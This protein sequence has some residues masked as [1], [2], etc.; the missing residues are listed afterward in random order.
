MVPD[1]DPQ[2][3]P[4]PHGEDRFVGLIVSDKK[5]P[6]TVEMIHKGERSLSFSGASGGK[7]VDGSF[8]RYH[9]RRGSQ[10]LGCVNQLAFD[11][12]RLIDASIMKSQTIPF[13]FDHD[14][15]VGEKPSLGSFQLFHPSRADEIHVV[16]HGGRRQRTFGSM[17]SDQMGHRS[18]DARR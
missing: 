15:S 2:R 18:V 8:A 1:T 10:P 5:Q 11:G 7:K 12:A 14:A 4:V 9:S 17:V 6:R 16:Q 13:V 3:Q